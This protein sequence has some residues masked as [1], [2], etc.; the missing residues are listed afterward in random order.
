MSRRILVADDSVTIRKIVEITF[1]DTDIRV[2]AVASG[3]EALER[4]SEAPPDLVIADVVMPGPSGYEVCE[5]IKASARPVPVL[6]LAGTFEPFDRKRAVSC[7]ADGHLVKPFESRTLLDRVAD[8]LSR[9]EAAPLPVPEAE[10]PPPSEPALAS[11]RIGEPLPRAPWEVGAAAPAEEGGASPAAGP[12]AAAPADG[13]ASLGAEEDV[14]SSAPA[15]PS[16]EFFDA[17]VHEV[18]RRLSK[19][20][21][22]EIAWDVVPDL[23]ETIIRDRLRDIEREERERG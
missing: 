19:D 17:V 8:L 23:A 4:F 18:V 10:A 6:L 21:V 14:L 11:A 20:V 22:Q 12:E 16:G 13:Q 1:S 5:R 2:D 9:K 15:L 3:A 7:G